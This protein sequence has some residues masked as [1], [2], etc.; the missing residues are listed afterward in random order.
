MTRADFGDP[1]SMEKIK[2][3]IANEFVKLV[4]LDDSKIENPFILMLMNKDKKSVNFTQRQIGIERLRV[5]SIDVAL[6]AM[7]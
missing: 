6:S 3:S 4:Y 1:L 2:I 5:F 7:L